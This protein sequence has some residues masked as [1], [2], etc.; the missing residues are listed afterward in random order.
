MTGNWNPAERLFKEKI[1]HR[2]SNAQMAQLLQGSTYFC[3]LNSGNKSCFNINKLPVDVQAAL[4]GAGVDFFYVMTGE[5]A[6]SDG[7]V[8]RQAFDYA[9]STL[10]TTLQDEFRQQVCGLPTGIAY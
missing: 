4:L 9:I 6:A 3:D 1:R 7:S 2:I 8:K 5:Y 10:P